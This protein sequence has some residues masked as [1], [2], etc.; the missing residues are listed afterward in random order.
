[1]LDDLRLDLAATLLAFFAIT[2]HVTGT[3]RLWRA[4]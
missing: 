2:L 1:M 3:L 4:K